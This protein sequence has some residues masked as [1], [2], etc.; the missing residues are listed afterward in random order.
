MKTRCPERILEGIRIGNRGVPAALLAMLCALGGSH[1][2]FSQTVPKLNDTG[3]VSCYNASVAIA[4]DP[5]ARDA[6]THP[7]QDARY[8]RDAKK[9]AALLTKV[10]AGSGSFDFTKICRNGDAA[11]TG[12]CP[13]DPAQG[14]GATD[15]GCTL[16]N[17]TGLL[18]ELKTTAPATLSYSGHKYT[19]YSTNAATNGGN[20]GN[21]GANSCNGTLP[22]GLCNTE[23]FIAAI[24]SA[25]LCGRSDWRVPN[26]LEM[27]S[28]I[29]Y[30]KGSLAFDTNYFPNSA[31]GNYWTSRTTAFNVTEAFFFSFNLGD[32]NYDVKSGNYF[33]QAVSKGQ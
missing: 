21:Q 18:W 7:R 31:G 6:G 14:S 19:W 5:A 28:R 26:E 12:T 29:D 25:A 30:S 16:D 22:G 10:G 4:C 8:G 15:W 23:A 3:V 1:P 24:N 2:S 9:S 17:V 11:G 32:I 13:A 33:A 27:Q 20:V